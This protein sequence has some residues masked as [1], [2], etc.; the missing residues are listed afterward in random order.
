MSPPLPFDPIDEAARQWRAHWPEAPVEAMSA[1]TSVMRAQQILLGRLNEALDPFGL[2]FARYEALLLLH[3]SR[4]G[5]LPLGKMGARLQ[6]HPASV[7]NLINGLEADGYVRREPHPSDRRT[8]LAAITPQGRRIA[9]QATA[10]M[11]EI[12]FGT[13]PLQDAQLQEITDVLRGARSGA[14]DFAEPARPAGA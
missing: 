1:V 4:A 12:R 13:A 8:T 14:G 10:R 11:H 6:V 7:T 2:T 9:E 3:F 5:S